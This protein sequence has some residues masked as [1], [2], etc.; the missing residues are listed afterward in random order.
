M[1]TP[2]LIQYPT[3][4]HTAYVLNSVLGAIWCVAVFVRTNASPLR[5]GVTLA[6]VHINIHSSYKF[7]VVKAE[8]QMWRGTGNRS[9]A[10]KLSNAP[11]RPQRTDA[12]FETLK[13]VAI[14]R[15]CLGH[16]SG[17]RKTT[18]PYTTLITTKLLH[19][20]EAKAV[21]VKRLSLGNQS[22]GRNGAT[23]PWKLCRRPQWSD[24]A[25]ETVKAAAQERRGIRNHPGGYNETTQ[26]GDTVWAAA[27]ER[28]GPRAYVAMIVWM[29]IR[30]YVYCGPLQNAA[31]PE[32]RSGQT[33]EMEYCCPVARAQRLM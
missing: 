12:A 10:T 19:N 6:Y 31:I 22:G 3:Q 9:E 29:N 8:Q 17:G 27:W 18:R 25:L 24:T 15:R 5:N 28:H 4:H 1:T 11:R 21:A 2:L 32:Q 30:T 33:G 14:K 7:S 13:A 20:S 26:H 23:L 16:Y